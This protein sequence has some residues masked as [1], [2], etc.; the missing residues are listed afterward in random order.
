[1][2]DW[3]TESFGEDYI[4]VYRHRNREN[5]AREVGAMMEWMNIRA[6]SR[7][8]DV[9]C[10]TGRHA[11]ALRKLGYEVTG[12]DLSEVLLSE[13]RCSDSGGNVAWIRGDMRCLPFEEGTFD[14][15]VNWFTS[16]GYF[17]ECRDNLSVLGE[18]ERVLKPGGRYLIDFLNPSYV[19]RHLVPQSERVDETTGLHITE[20][21]TIEDD[22]VVK[23][24]EVRPPLDGMGNRGEARHYEERVRLIGLEQ[25][26]KMLGET[27]LK[28][29][30]VYGDYDGSAYAA[31]SSKRQILL[32]RKCE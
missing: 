19:L 16:F 1:M 2:R 18:M 7:V 3:F 8:L 4:V 25:F 30:S 20:K 6:G 12:L 10:G 14:A 15:T 32:G 13:A 11:M 24:I 29:E 31:E 23:K 28:L 9:G 5:A 21:R 26:E 27:G 17:V 22:F